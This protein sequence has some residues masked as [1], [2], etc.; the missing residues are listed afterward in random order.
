MPNLNDRLRLWQAA[1]PAEVPL[2][3]TIDWQALAKQLV[4]SGGEIAAIAHEA[5]LYA[6]ATEAETLDMNHLTHVLA[7][8]GKSVNLPLAVPRLTKTSKTSKTKKSQKA[9]TAAPRLNPTTGVTKLPPPSEPADP[10]RQETSGNE[11][12]KRKQAS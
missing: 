11:R 1:F 4:L 6:A 10:P 9:K 7:Q 3:Q 5:V 12:R 8:R 2:S